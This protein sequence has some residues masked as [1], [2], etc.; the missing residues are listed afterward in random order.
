MRCLPVIAATPS[1]RLTCNPGTPMLKKARFPGGSRRSRIQAALLHA[2]TGEQAEPINDKPPQ[3]QTDGSAPYPDPKW[4]S[5]L[6]LTKDGSPHNALGN[7]IRTL[8][9]SPYWHG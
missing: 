5:R 2:T 7:L 3:E 9:F 4:M 1:V 6:S 8:Q